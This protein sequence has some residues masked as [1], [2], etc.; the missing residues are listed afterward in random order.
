MSSRNN[1]SLP[2]LPG[3]LV[4]WGTTTFGAGLAQPLLA[5]YLKETVGLPT[6]GVSFY[7]GLFAVAGLAVNPLIGTF[8]ARWDPGRVAVFAT[9]PQTAGALLLVQADSMS[10]VMLA[11]LL[12]GSGTGT[13][14]AVQT[15]VLS[16][17]FGESS[18]SRV[19]SAQNQITAATMALGAVAGG[20]LADRL[21]TTGFQLG[22]AGNGV[23]YLLY[24]IALARVLRLRYGAGARPGAFS[25]GLEDGP[26]ERGA[27]RRRTPFTNTT[28]LLLL[29]LQ[30]ALVTFGLVQLDTVLP[31]VLRDAA[32]L[33]VSA[34]S[35][36]LAVNSLSVLL[37]QPLAL[38]VVHRIGYVNALRAAVGVWAV[39]LTA[40]FG[41]VHVTGQ[42]LQLTLAA[43][44]ALVFSVGECLIAPSVQPLVVA[45]APPGRMP[46]YAAATSLVHG[47]GGFLAP[48]MCLP[49]FT[50]GGIQAY[51]ILQL[52]GYATAAGTLV[53]LG[54]RT[55]HLR[56]EREDGKQLVGAAPD[57]GR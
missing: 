13:Y 29:L 15:P 42:W 1:R 12:S 19:L 8:G 54:R 56:Q 22:I 57:G 6:S 34:G 14:Y 27:A 30:G 10:T 26:R 33:S 25:G 38:R 52:V 35:L 50:A 21:G 44:F 7:F 16:G 53:P 48:M 9:V 18:L 45:L 39:S 41:A 11:A 32:K 46:A 36:V 4:G 17:A 31:V 5:V 3:F 43:L 40:L 24:G 28:F 23:S 2:L 47:L 51:L 55:R 20:Q 49:V 37:I